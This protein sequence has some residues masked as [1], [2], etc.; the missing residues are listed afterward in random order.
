MLDIIA[1]AMMVASRM[2]AADDQP[3]CPFDEK[4]NR[5]KARSLGVPFFSRILNKSPGKPA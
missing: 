3:C 1:N 2:Q 4:S 5:W